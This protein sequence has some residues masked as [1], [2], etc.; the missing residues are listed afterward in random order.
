MI[1]E[2][3][4]LDRGNRVFGGVPAGGRYHLWQFTDALDGLHTCVIQNDKLS[5][6]SKC[7]GS[8]M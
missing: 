2:N 1:L 8:N 3:F 6:P 7:M 5:L 4:C